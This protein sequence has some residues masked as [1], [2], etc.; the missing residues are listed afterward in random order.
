MMSYAVK[1]LKPWAGNFFSGSKKM[2][3]TFTLFGMLMIASGAPSNVPLSV[4]HY[5]GDIQH[6]AR[7]SSC[8]VKWVYDINVRDVIIDVG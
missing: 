4:R 1:F 2:F 6:E 5:N 7:P 8:E 3:I